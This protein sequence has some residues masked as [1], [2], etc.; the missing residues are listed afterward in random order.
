MAAPKADFSETLAS[1][2]HPDHAGE[3]TA[4]RLQEIYRN[5]FERTKAYRRVVWQL[6]TQEFF[7]KMVDPRATVLDLGCGYG[8]FINQISA[9]RKYGMDLNPDSAGAL[10]RDVEFLHQDCATE[11][12]LP[13]DS[14]DVVFTSNFFEH[15]PDKSALART[16]AEIAR[17][18]RPGGRVIAMGPNM[19]C[20]GGS[21][22]HFW[23][24]EIPLTHLS[25]QELM[26]L[27]DLE[28]ERA[29]KSFLPYTL[30]N[31]PCYPLSFVRIYLR[32]R[33]LWRIFGGQFLVIA[34]KR[35]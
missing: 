30:V 16:V 7:Q 23:D 10:A 34:R 8:E 18:L 35:H 33:I 13:N 2:P 14:L 17:C 27:N 22:W 19:A 4:R 11:W 25:M 32:F 26:R 15:L 31:Q 20:L 5:R 29:E 24:H 12:P 6:L 28:V 1:D 21:Y 3:E 9:G